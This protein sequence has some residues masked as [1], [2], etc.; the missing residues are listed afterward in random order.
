MSSVDA[1]GQQCKGSTTSAAEP[2]GHTI[3]T[4][5]VRRTASPVRLTLASRLGNE[6]NGGWWSRMRLISRELPELV[7]VLDV[8]FGQVIDVDVNWSVLQR[9]P[10][11]NWDWWGGIQ[12]HIMTVGGR[13]ARAKLLI[14]PYRTRTALAVMVSRWAAGLPINAAHRNSLA[15]HTAESI[16]RVAGGNV[17]IRRPRRDGLARHLEAKRIEATL[18]LGF[19]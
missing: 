7:S 4:A 1:V 13:D 14:V 17:E 18:I 5:E 11:L 12:P 8:H 19:C 3:G 15:C 2:T 16:V 9:Q 6:I 10:G